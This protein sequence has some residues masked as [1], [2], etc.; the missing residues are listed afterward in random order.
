MGRA[1][2]RITRAPD[3]ASPDGEARTARARPHTNASDQ[4][5]SVIVPG[6][7][8]PGPAPLL[9]ANTAAVAAPPTTIAAPPTTYQRVYQRPRSAPPPAAT[10]SG[11]GSSG[12]AMRPVASAAGPRAST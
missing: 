3:S 9:A 6:G 2:T 11:S 5:D 8:L 1:M 12:L 4:G 7:K 10:W